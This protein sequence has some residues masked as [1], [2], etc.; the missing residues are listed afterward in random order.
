MKSSSG[1]R[2]N[3]RHQARFCKKSHKRWPLKVVIWISYFLVSPTQLVDLLVDDMDGFMLDLN[4]VSKMLQTK[5]MQRSKY[6]SKCFKTKV[7]KGTI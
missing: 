7:L 5:S 2:T 3:V 4:I 6:E 1:S